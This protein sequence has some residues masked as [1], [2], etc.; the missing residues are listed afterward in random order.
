M[1]LL[2]R[3]LPWDSWEKGR[4]LPRA[5]IMKSFH[6]R[7]YVVVVNNLTHLRTWHSSGSPFE[8]TTSTF[9]NCGKSVSVPPLGIQDTLRNN[10]YHPSPKL[11]T[12][13]YLIHTG[14]TGK[15]PTHIRSKCLSAPYL[16]LVLFPQRQGLSIHR[17]AS[18]W[19]LACY[20][21]GASCVHHH[22]SLRKN[23]T[24][25]FCYLSI[26]L[27]KWSLLFVFFPLFLMLHP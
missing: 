26:L 23:Q 1:G 7:H 12:P 10:K 24:C 3:G 11:T 20:W 13:R 4:P 14:P 15:W 9:P 25:L 19:Q 21:P 22:C 16:I 18:N 5:A 8:G 17:L 2:L 6:Y 27:S